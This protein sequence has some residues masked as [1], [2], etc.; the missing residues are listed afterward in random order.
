MFKISIWDNMHVAIKGTDEER[1]KKLREI[2]A[3]V[4]AM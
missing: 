2:V 4:A 3:V 1:E